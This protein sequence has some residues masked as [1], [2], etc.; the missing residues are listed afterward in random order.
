MAIILPVT[1]A[2]EAAI[3]PIRFRNTTHTSRTIIIPASSKAVV[4]EIGPVAR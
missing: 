3:T 4:I 2:R 1:K